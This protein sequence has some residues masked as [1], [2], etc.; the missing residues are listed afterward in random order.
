MTIWQLQTNDMNQL[1]ALR[2]EA[3]ATH[4]N[5]VQNQHEGAVWGQVA[6]NLP[7][8]AVVERQVSDT[9]ITET[10]TFTNTSAF[11]VYVDSDKLGITLPL[12]DYYA[13]AVTTQTNCCNVHLWC[14]G[15]SS[16][17]MAMKMGGGPLNLGLILTQGSLSGYRVERDPELYS[18]D[19]GTFIVQVGPTVIDPG[20]SYVLQWQ[21]VGFSDRE[22]FKRQA[23]AHPDFVW[24]EAPQFT[25]FETEVPTLTITTQRDAY[26][27]QLDGQPL[28]AATCALAL[29]HLAVGAHR[30]SVLADNQLLAEA[31]LLVQPPLLDLAEKRCAFLAAHQQADLPGQALDGAYLIYDNETHQQ[32]YQHGGDWNAGRERIGMGVL[33]ARL[34][35]QRPDPALEASLMRYVAFVE[36]ELLDPATG[37]VFNDAPRNKDV[38]RTYNEPWVAVLMMELYNLT[39]EPR[40]LRQMV[41]I[42]RRYAQETEGKHYGIGIPMVESIA[43]LKQAG[44]ADETA[45]LLADFERQGQAMLQNG[46]HYPVHEVKYEQSIVAPAA[47]YMSMLY[48]LTGKPEYAAGAAVQLGQ[49]ERFN[50]QQPDYHLY[51]VAIRHWDGYWFG[52][53]EQFGD[54]FPH[55]WSA[56]S[57]VAFAS[58]AALPESTWAKRAQAALRGVLS[59]FAP[60]GSASCAMVYPMKVNDVWTHYYDPWANDQDW[61]LYFM[62]KYGQN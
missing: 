32:F 39:R 4:M 27:V 55:Y 42:L 49:L 5:W 54:T 50:G 15:A 23:L 19:R 13:D 53:R 57:G 14:R 12:P 62:L 17:I 24:L 11:P 43:L 36:R 26:Q 21:L 20:Q 45:A 30:V 59:L 34:L 46:I 33:M 29:P 60:D 8:S 10:Y 25:W 41:A 1:T 9:A 44:M 22:D 37:E 31:E 58:A 18:N 38:V 35:Q 51:E 47:T 52:K 7:L 6:T 48:Q 61:G 2:F 40:Y 28:A 16:Y 56:L 3:D